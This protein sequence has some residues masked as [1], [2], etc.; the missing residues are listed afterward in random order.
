MQQTAHQL[1]RQ[2]TLPC[3]HDLTLTSRSLILNCHLQ[4]RQ[5]NTKCMKAI[6][7]VRRSCCPLFGSEMVREKELGSSR[8]G[9]AFALCILTTTIG[10]EVPNEMGSL[11][12]DSHETTT[13]L[14]QG[15][16]T[17]S[18]QVPLLGGERTSPSAFARFGEIRKHL[19]PPRSRRD[20]QL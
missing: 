15:Q 11:Q 5:A 20:R 6:L 17:L 7:S 19:P 14:A 16:P 18:A 3:N 9:I 12:C 4:A 1:T 10:Q 8:T 2:G 13:N